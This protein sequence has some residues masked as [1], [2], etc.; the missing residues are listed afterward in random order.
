[1]GKDRDPEWLVTEVLGSLFDTPEEMKDLILRLHRKV[2]PWPRGMRMESGWFL[3]HLCS[4][5]L[6]EKKT[7]QAEQGGV[8]IDDLM[9]DICDIT[10]VEMSRLREP[11]RGPR[12][13]PERRFAVWR[14]TGVHI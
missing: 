13:N 1:M 12:G 14:F 6:K 4:V 2:E 8:R 7:E 5:D 11:I 9:K 10:G 3:W